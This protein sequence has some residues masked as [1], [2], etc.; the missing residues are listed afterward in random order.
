MGGTSNADTQQNITQ[1]FVTVPAAD[2]EVALRVDAACM[3][4][5]DD[6]EEQ[7]AQERG[8]IEQEVSRDFSNP[9]YKFMARVNQGLFEGTPYAHDALGTKPSFD[10]TTAADLKKYFKDWYAPNNAIL[11]IAG[12]VDPT[13]SLAT[14]KKLYGSIPRRD[15]GKHPDF[16]LKPVKA[17]S[18]T[19]ESNLPYVL[20]FVSFR[21][22]GTSDPDFAA[23]KILADVAGSQRADIFGLVPL[24]R[25]W[26]RNSPSRKRIRKP[27]RP[28]PWRRFRPAPTP[29]PSPLS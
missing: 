26:P 18:F 15:V 11:V 17:D 6:S 9:T 28:L 19:L 13:A 14:V 12:D 23:A 22:P 20:V 27:V 1:Y 21:M 29:R 4:D 24:T 2:L 10:K 5:V 8:A 16:E 3:A 25:L 7:W